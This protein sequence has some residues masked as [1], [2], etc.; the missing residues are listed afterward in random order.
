[1][2]K[3]QLFN[4]NGEEVYCN[5]FSES[6]EVVEAHAKKILPYYLHGTTAY[7][8][9]VSPLED[10]QFLIDNSE[11]MVEV[12]A[13]ILRKVLVQKLKTERELKKLKEDFE[14]LQENLR[15]SKD[16]EFRLTC[17]EARKKFVDISRY[18]K[19]I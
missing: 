7:I 2:L 4:G 1:M 13:Q 18:T 5:T 19:E 3:L 11:G 8:S 16:T 9:I 12:D 6:I 10:D 15:I 17:L 14:K